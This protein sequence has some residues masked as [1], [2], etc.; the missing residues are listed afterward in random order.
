MATVDD[1]NRDIFD[2]IFQNRTQKFC[3]NR[4]KNWFLQVQKIINLHYLAGSSFDSDFWSY[5][6]DLAQ[7]CLAVN[8][9]TYNEIIK[10]LYNPNFILNG[11]YGTWGVHSFRQNIEGLNLGHEIENISSLK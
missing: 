11:N 4:Y 3:N 1:I 8:D 2:I 9:E 5:A 6:Q 7:Q 10:N